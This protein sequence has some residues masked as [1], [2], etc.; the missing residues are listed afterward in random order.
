MFVRSNRLWPP[1]SG[2]VSSLKSRVVHRSD[3]TCCTCEGDYISATM[4]K[5][6]ESLF[7]SIDI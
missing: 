2:I 4:S 6:R 1:V 5:N 3:G 7:D